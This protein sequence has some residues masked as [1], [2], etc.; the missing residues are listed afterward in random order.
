[1]KEFNFRKL[2][3]LFIAI[4]LILSFF[5]KHKEYYSMPEYAQI[6]E[7]T[8][9]YKD[10]KSLENSNIICLLEPTYFVQIISDFNDNLLLV[11]Y[12]GINGYVQK[13]SIKFITGSPKIPY[14]ILN[15]TC[16]NKCNLRSSPKS[17]STT[18]IPIPTNAE[19]K[20]IGKVY[21][22]SI[23][24]YNGETWYFIEY[25]GVRGYIYNG[26]ISSL[27]VVLPNTETVSFFENY[28]YL[29][30]NP[31]S[32]ESCIIIISLITI[33]SIFILILLFKK[34]KPIKKKQTIIRKND[35]IDYDSLL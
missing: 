2:N 11:S 4:L 15:L 33:P 9:L 28:D 35:K 25:L 13:K 17:D 12:H 26:Y 14:P 21:G 20:Y 8:A 24:D 29:S 32:N 27:P 31:L 30:V 18:L 7:S 19:V 5:P 16:S 6:I 3:I 34:P 1:M 22:D 10:E 23:M